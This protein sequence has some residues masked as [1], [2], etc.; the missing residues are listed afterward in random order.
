MRSNGKDRIQK[1]NALL[2]PFYQ[3]TVIRY[4]AAKVIMQ[5]LIDV[6]QRRR[7]LYIRLYGKAQPVG[8]PGSVLRVL[9]QD[10]CLDFPERCKSK[11]VEY[12][13][14]WGIHN[15]VCILFNDLL[16]QFSV[17]RFGKFRL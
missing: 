6:Y 14:R 16:I 15:M 3:I 9:P 11:C 10:H 7:D 1:K 5:F 2:S 17:I 12:I 8:L 4:I 13:L